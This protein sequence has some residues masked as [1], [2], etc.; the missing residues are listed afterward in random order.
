M[1]PTDSNTFGDEQLAV[2]LSTDKLLFKA[3]EHC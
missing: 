3:L 1:L 2:E